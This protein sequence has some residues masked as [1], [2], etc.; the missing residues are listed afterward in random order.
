[1]AFDAIQQILIG[2]AL[3][4]LCA[5]SGNAPARTNQAVLTSNYNASSPLTILPKTAAAHHQIHCP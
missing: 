4:V 1:M 2:F 5:L 3:I